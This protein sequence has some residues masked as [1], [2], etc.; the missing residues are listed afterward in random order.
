MRDAGTAAIP[1]YDADVEADPTY[2][3]AALAM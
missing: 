2:H 1:P 3:W